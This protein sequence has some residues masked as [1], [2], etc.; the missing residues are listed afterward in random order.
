MARIFTN[1][2]SRTTSVLIRGIRV[3]YFRF[4]ISD[5]SFGGW[6]DFNAALSGDVLRLGQP[7][8]AKKVSRP[9]LF[10]QATR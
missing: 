8:S 9:P 7:R 2:L 6:N 1:R 10:H 3:K 5:V 4:L